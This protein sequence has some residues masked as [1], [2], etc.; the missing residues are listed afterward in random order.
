GPGLGR[1][2]RNQPASGVR[3]QR[4]QYGQKNKHARQ[5]TKTVLARINHGK[6]SIS[7]CLSLPGRP[8]DLHDTYS[9]VKSHKS[10]AL[11]WTGPARRCASRFDSRRSKTAAT[12]RWRLSR[13]QVRVH[14]FEDQRAHFG[15]LDVRAV[16]QLDT[17]ILR[18]A[19]LR[20]KRHEVVTHALDARRRRQR[21]QAAVDAEAGAGVG[22]H[23]ELSGVK[24]LEHRKHILI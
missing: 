7:R 4:A 5:T 22:Q 10:F 15:Q 23:V 6:T 18:V 1:K 19:V 9:M 8:P 3:G 16:E 17:A 14:P 2:L 24:M 12:V 13:Y 21:V 11:H 20:V